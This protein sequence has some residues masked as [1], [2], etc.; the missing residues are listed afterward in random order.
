MTSYK[1]LGLVN[2][3]DM[4]AKAMKGGYA[5]PAFNFNNMEQM[6]AII[7]ACVEAKS[8]RFQRE[9]VLTQTPTSFAIWP[10]A[11]SSTHTSLAVTFRSSF[12]WITVQ[13]LRSARTV[14]TTDSLL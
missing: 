5:I 12:T 13:T 11:P 8:F 9:L 14:S 3:K 10:V 1:E 7:M 6:Q 4:F 2:T